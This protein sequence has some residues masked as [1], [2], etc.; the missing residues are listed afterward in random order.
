M[1]EPTIKNPPYLSLKFNIPHIV[2]TNLKVLKESSKNKNYKKVSIYQGIVGAKLGWCWVNGDLNIGDIV[3]IANE[4][5]DKA[6][7]EPIDLPDGKIANTL[8]F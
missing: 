4:L 6:K 8:V 5:Y 2:I 3:E 7:V 1:C